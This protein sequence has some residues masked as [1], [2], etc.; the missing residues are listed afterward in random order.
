M[1]QLR[2]QWRTTSQGILFID[3][4]L[5]NTSSK[6][7]HIKMIETRS[8]KKSIFPGANFTATSAYAIFSPISCC[9]QIRQIF[10]LLISLHLK[11]AFN[12]F[13]CYC[14]EHGFDVEVQFGAYLHVTHSMPV[15]CLLGILNTDL[16]LFIE[17]HLGS[18]Q[19]FGDALIDFLEG[20]LHP[21]GD[22]PK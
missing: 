18:H 20:N 19:Q 15:C 3:L 6:T 1:E 4:I 14:E 9:I 7:E 11:S 21:F 13:L 12:Q 8:I 16:S 2:S 17:I 22:I 5:N 10:P